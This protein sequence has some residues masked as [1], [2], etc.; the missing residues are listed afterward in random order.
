[1]QD[2]E[3]TYF[4]V[5]FFS[6]VGVFSKKGPHPYLLPLPPAR[7]TDSQVSTGERER[8]R[9]E[10]KGLGGTGAAGRRLPGS[11]ARAPR[12]IVPGLLHL[13]LAAVR[14]PPASP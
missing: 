12:A 3:D 11:G 14:P 1:M 4:Y 13:V 5:G 7:L 10:R 8:E 2:F 6:F 9:P